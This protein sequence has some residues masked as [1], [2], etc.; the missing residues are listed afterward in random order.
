MPLV[1]HTSTSQATDMPL[2]PLS[3]RRI[4]TTRDRPGR[5]DSSLAGLG[6]DVI[7][8]PLIRIEDPP[9]GGTS[10]ARAL[11]RIHE[12]DWVVVTSRH[13]ATRIAAS[14]AGH[15]AIRLA[16]VGSRTA[17]ALASA[18]GREVDVVPERQ[19][20]ADL[21]GSMSG[22]SG[23][24]LVAQA[25]RA[26]ATLAAG[27]TAAGFEVEVVTAYR[28]VLRAP[29]EPERAAA[30]DADALIL[31]SGS[32]AEAW[33]DA[34]GTVAPPVVAAIGPQTAAAAE[35]RGLKVSHVAADHHVEGLVDVVLTAFTTAP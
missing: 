11:A 32:A 14:V 9:A 21:V 17:S 24:V 10:L 15:P 3:G 12:F 34:F 13:G 8:V 1:P 30:I 2:R 19:T 26:D 5:L 25:D 29:S 27:L 6:A 33:A 35:R 7:H 20:A 4:V 22:G 31:A 28:T 23:R 16:A 18:T